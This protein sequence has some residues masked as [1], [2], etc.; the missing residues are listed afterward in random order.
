M[1][2]NTC[3]RKINSLVGS[4]EGNT[5]SSGLVESFL[6]FIDVCQ[7]YSFASFFFFFSW[8]LITLQYCS[9]FCHALT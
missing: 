2:P 6:R 8:R 7:S 9:G 3:K 5:P 1:F 4:G